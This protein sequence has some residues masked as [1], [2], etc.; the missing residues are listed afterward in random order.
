MGLGLGA[1][2]A[3]AAR[4]LGLAGLMLGAG[5]A[6]VAAQDGPWYGGYVADLPAGTTL[7]VEADLIQFAGQPTGLADLTFGAI[8]SGSCPETIHPAFCDEMRARARWVTQGDGDA[9]EARVFGVRVEQD[10][11]HAAFAFNDEG[12]LRLLELRPT[13]RGYA[14]AIYHPQRGLDMAIPAWRRAHVCQTRACPADPRIEAL[15]RNPYP[16]LGVLG[17]VRFAESFPL[18][19]D[20]I[21]EAH[22]Q[23]RAIRPEPASPQ[24]S[25]GPDLRGIGGTWRIYDDAGREVGLLAMRARDGEVTGRGLVFD[26]PGLPSRAELQPVAQ[27]E[28]PD[29]VQVEFEVRNAGNG[30]SQGGSLVMAMPPQG[31]TIRAAYGLAGQ[32]LPVTL[33]REGPF[34]PAAVQ[35]MDTQPSQLPA[36]LPPRPKPQ[37]PKPQPK[38]QPPK[39]KPQPKPDPLP[40]AVPGLFEGAE[41]GIEAPSRGEGMLK[42]HAAR[43]ISS[44]VTGRLAPGTRGVVVT[45]CTRGITPDTFARPRA[46]GHGK[47][48]AEGWCEIV[49]GKVKGWVQADA[50]AILRM[51]A[52]VPTPKPEARLSDQPFKLARLPGGKTAVEVH[53]ARAI[54]SNVAGVL[55]AGTRGILVTDCQPDLTPAHFR[56]PNDP[57]HRKALEKAWCKISVGTVSGFVPAR[58]L[59]LQ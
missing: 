13:A 53:V 30:N 21:A 56:R 14:L 37:P 6:P 8:A 39:P 55:P 12:V 19:L 35:W 57:A 45:R 41:F 26:R 59:T 23:R 50:L 16:N 17:D 38:P 34:D 15:R 58:V 44:V 42:V 9:L 48:L 20:G 18:G 7:S 29:R 51:P 32:W 43:A 54:S 28:A 3:R 24:V 11:V 25:A 27:A 49:S 52:L 36:P 47:A 4:A 40:P 46:Q 2:L 5:G 1:A 33:Y 10:I 31:D 22:R